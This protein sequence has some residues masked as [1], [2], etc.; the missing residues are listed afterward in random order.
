MPELLS[1]A[2]SRRR[3]DKMEGVNIGM[4][5]TLYIHEGEI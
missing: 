5:T 4:V 1:G 2:V 3:A